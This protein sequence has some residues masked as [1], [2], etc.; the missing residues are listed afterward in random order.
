MAHTSMST[1]TRN[2]VCRSLCGLAFVSSLLPLP[3]RAADADEAVV[4]K[5]TAA[6]FWNARIQDEWGTVFDLMSLEEQ[7]AIKD[8]EAFAS[9]QK[10]K[11]WF[12]YEKV[13]I[14]ES[15]VDRVV[16]WVDVSYESSLRLYPTMPHQNVKLWQIWRKTD[17]WRPV[18][19]PLLE[20]YPQRPPMLRPA[21]EEAIIAKRTEALWKARKE[22]N[23]GVVYDLSMPEYRKSISK[24]NFLK[25]K[26]KYQYLKYQLDWVEADGAAARSKVLYTQ[27]LNDPTLHKL[28]PTDEVAFETWVKAKDGVWYRFVKPEPPPEP[29]PA[30]NTKAAPAAPATDAKPAAAGNGAP[31]GPAAAGAATPASTPSASP[32]PSNEGR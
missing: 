6:K 26:S 21:A 5:D 29:P 2:L 16:G 22:Q 1:Y 32:K 15:A 17:Q 27:K 14:G 24:K 10:E 31:A 4:L 9:Y 11:G 20:Q 30:K 23:W 18:P 25:R 7:Q 8:R 19:Q 13:E 3:A 28:A 12:K